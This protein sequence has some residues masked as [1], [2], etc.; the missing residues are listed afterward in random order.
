MD[1]HAREQ[2]QWRATIIA[3][4]VSVTALGI[5]QLAPFSD[6]LRSQ[7]GVLTVLLTFGIWQMLYGLLQ[8]DDK[9]GH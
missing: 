5:E 8:P 4:V 3:L 7:I 1:D 2:A 9:K 6:A